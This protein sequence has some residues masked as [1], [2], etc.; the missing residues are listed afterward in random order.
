MNARIGPVIFPAI[1]IGLRG[2]DRLEALALQRRLLRGPH[3]AL[4][5]AFSIRIADAAWQRDDT[6]MAQQVAIER[7]ECRVVDVGREDALFQVIE[8]DDL[9]RAAEPTKRPLVQLA[10]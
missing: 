9:R 6:V 3:S 5:F 2:L 8:D 1:E 10:P 4:D 7:I